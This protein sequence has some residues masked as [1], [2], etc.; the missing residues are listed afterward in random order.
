MQEM[1]SF[2]KDGASAMTTLYL[3]YYK[4]NSKFPDYYQYFSQITGKSASNPVLFIYD[5]E[6]YSKDKPLHEFVNKEKKE[7][8]SMIDKIEKEGWVSMILKKNLYIVTNPLV[9]SKKECEI[10]E[11]FT[12][13]TLQKEINGKTFSLGKNFDTNNYFGKDIFS[14]IIAKEYEQIDFS[15]FIPF[16]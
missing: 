6:L 12:A 9:D 1:F 4:K 15:R 2:V 10:E 14:K 5:N 13:E 16:L 3:N 8:E 11:L 7:K